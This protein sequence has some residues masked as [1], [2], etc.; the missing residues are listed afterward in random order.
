LVP[1][2]NSSFELFSCYSP[3]LEQIQVSLFSQLFLP[4]N[5]E[6]LKLRLYLHLCTFTFINLICYF[7][8]LA[9]H[10][11][12]FW[13]IIRYC[14]SFLISIFLISFSFFG[15][16]LFLAIHW[17]LHNHPKDYFFLHLYIFGDIQ[18]LLFFIWAVTGARFPWFIFPLGV[19][20][21]LLGIHS[22]FRKKRQAAESQND[23]L[24]QSPPE[25]VNVVVNPMTPVVSPSTATTPNGPLM[26][27]VPPPPEYTQIYPQQPVNWR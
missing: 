3:Y 2:S 17:S 20:S 5:R 8:W 25:V 24:N 1:V 27:Y 10:Q 21:V 22:F 7:T 4:F 13:P 26:V 11:T 9:T 23:S 6:S 19:F 18:L 12:F 14:P 16:A 15:L